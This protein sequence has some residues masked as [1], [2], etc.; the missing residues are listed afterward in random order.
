MNFYC[1]PSEPSWLPPSVCAS[2]FALFPLI[3][4]PCSGRVIPALSPPHSQFPLFT[5]GEAAERDPDKQYEGICKKAGRGSNKRA[6]ARPS[7]DPGRWK[8]EVCS[9]V[10]IPPL[11]RAANQ[12]STAPFL[13]RWFYPRCRERSTGHL[14]QPEL[15]VPMCSLN[16]S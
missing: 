6:E 1:L 11:S 16:N 8:W 2:L 13:C 14:N 7:W 9:A 15:L 4:D 10:S 5:S 12:S 3:L